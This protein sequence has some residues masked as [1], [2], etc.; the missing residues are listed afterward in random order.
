MLSRLFRRKPDA[1][2][3]NAKH[4]ENLMASVRDVIDDRMISREAHN[5]RVTE[6]LEASK[7][8]VEEKRELSA[9]LVAATETAEMAIYI[10]RKH[11]ASSLAYDYARK[12]SDSS[13]FRCALAAFVLGFTGETIKISVPTH[14]EKLVEDAYKAGR[15]ARID[16]E[17]IW[18]VSS[19]RAL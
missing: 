14:I 13:N 11:V 3:F 9:A 15:E 16:F 2:V 18:G 7:R 1:S 5:K 19:Y 6:L 8:L 4:V 10:M 12:E 17:Q